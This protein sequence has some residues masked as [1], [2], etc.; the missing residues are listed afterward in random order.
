[1]ENLF[2]KFIQVRKHIPFNVYAVKQLTII[3]DD[4]HGAN[5]VTPGKRTPTFPE[6][7]LMYE[8]EFNSRVVDLLKV[9]LERCGFRVLLSAPTGADTPLADRVKMANSAGADFFLSVHANANTGKWGEWGGIE[10][11]TYKLSGESNRIGK[12]LHKHLIGGTQL[13]D[14]GVKDGSGLYVVKNTKMPAVLVECAFMDNLK[15]ARLLKTEAYRQECTIELAK[16]IC[17][18]FGRSYV[19]KPIPK[20]PTPVEKPITA[21]TGKLFKVQCGAFS[22][23]ANAEALQKQLKDK[24]INAVIVLG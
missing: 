22:N 20:P 9:E 8:N 14:R 7:G 21:P 12:I 15:E 16:G 24:G 6:G 17:E 2:N 3:L 18:A 19:P 23:K 13:R 11:Y 4:G 5:G 10:T 1:M